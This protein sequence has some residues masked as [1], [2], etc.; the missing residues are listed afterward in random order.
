RRRTMSQSTA[1]PATAEPRL[2]GGWLTLARGFWLLL[3]LAL[4]ANFIASIPGYYQGLRTLCI[5][6]VG[7]CSAEWLPT[8][9]SATALHQLGFTL[10]NYAAYFISVDVAVSLVFWGVGLLIFWRKSNEWLG[11]F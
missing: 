11:L 1:S 8:P 2:R 7:E 4:L 9:D 10:D 5:G 3:A 6:D